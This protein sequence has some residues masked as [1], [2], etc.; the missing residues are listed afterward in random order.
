MIGFASIN[1]VVSEGEES[2][3]VT[4]AIL[5]GSLQTNLVLNVSFLN[6][7]AQGQYCCH[8]LEAKAEY[9]LV[10]TISYT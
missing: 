7:T 8:A 4:V 9:S 1:Y 10:Y 5:S 6:D 2:V 3:E